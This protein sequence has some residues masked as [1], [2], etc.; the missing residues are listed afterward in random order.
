MLLY[1]IRKKLAYAN[2]PHLFGVRKPYLQVL[3]Y[4]WQAKKKIEKKKKS[5]TKTNV[6]DAER[7]TN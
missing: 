5:K 1:C 4:L 6:K 2:L 3:K 7:V